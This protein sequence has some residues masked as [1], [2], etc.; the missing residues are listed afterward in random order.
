MRQKILILLCFIISQ[1]LLAKS[2]GLTELQ[3]LAYKNNNRLK[4]AQINTEMAGK[5]RDGSKGAFYPKFGI[6]AGVEQTTNSEASATD[7]EASQFI[8]GEYNLF[9]GFRDQNTLSKNTL[10]SKLRKSEYKETE[11]VLHLKIEK[12]Y[13]SYLYLDKSRNCKAS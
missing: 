5:K 8:Y 12:L 4:A 3:K 9:N 1:N 6:Q 11:F 2:L 10:N 7:S 13:Y